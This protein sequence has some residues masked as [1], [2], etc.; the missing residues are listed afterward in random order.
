[1]RA[2]HH[3]SFLLRGLLLLLASVGSSG[4]VTINPNTTGDLAAFE[5][6]LDWND[7]DFKIQ[8]SGNK[9]TIRTFGM[10]EGDEVFEH[11]IDGTVTGADAA[12]LN[13]DGFPEVVV[14]ITS[15]GSG[16]YGSIIGYSSNDGKSMSQ[17]TFPPTAENPKVNQ[18]YM[19][20]DKFTVAEDTFVQSFPVYLPGDT[21]AHPTGPTRQVQYALVDGEASRALVVSRTFEN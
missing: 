9:V 19:G 7:D 2:H 11:T 4:C 15:T 5:K 10:D 16:S 8:A 12:D 20:H 1:M 21:N 3:S 13:H 14:Y 6:S 17:I 18:G